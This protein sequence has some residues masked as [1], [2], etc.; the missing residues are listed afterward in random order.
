MQRL[1]GHFGHDGVRYVSAGE[2]TIG[3]LGRLLVVGQRGR[4]RTL[5]IAEDSQSFEFRSGRCAWS[6]F[7]G[8]AMI[9]DSVESGKKEDIRL[10]LGVLQWFKQVLDKRLIWFGEH[11]LIWRR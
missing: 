1:A 4:E 2:R 10:V 8:M 9:R 6:S 7:G 3:T 11:R 5:G